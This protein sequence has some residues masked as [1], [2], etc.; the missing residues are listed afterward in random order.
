MKRHSTDLLSLLPG[1]LFVAIAVLALAGGLTVDLLSADWV[2]P[3]ALIALG[4]LVLASA[5]RGRRRPDAH[6]VVTAPRADTDA[7]AGDAE[8]PGEPVQADHQVG[9][10]DEAR[11][12]DVR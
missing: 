1:L 7:T 9:H 11:D 2:W 10:G 6:D 4:V 3:S 12:D 5:G 8:P